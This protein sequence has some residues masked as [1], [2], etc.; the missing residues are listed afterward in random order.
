[1]YSSIIYVLDIIKEDGL[2]VNQRVKVKGLLLDLIQT[3]D[4]VFILHL[5]KTILSLTNELS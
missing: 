2:N 3:F 4:F 1:M 5:M